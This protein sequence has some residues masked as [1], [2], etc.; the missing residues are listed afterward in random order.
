MTKE[1]KFELT[2]EEVEVKCAKGMKITEEEYTRFAALCST[3]NLNPYTDAYI[4]K[5]D[6][7]TAIMIGKDGYFKMAD[8]N[9]AYDGMEDG[10][11]VMNKDGSYEEVPGCFIKEGQTLVGGWARAYRKDRKVP[12]FAA[13]MLKDYIGS[14]KSLWGRMPA[15]MINKVAKCTALRD[16]FPQA[17]AGTYA[18]GEIDESEFRSSAKDSHPEAEPAKLA[19]EP[20][21]VNTYEKELNCIIL[22]P[23]GDQMTVRDSI[24]SVKTLANAKAV[25]AYLNKYAETNEE[26]RESI[27]TVLDAIQKG[28][29]KFPNLN[30]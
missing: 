3:N 22:S 7:K 2:K 20:V 28:E 26:A 8:S 13:V 5:T 25:M 10:I 29:I 15:I 24:A 16:L 21:P 4:I 27:A 19:E 12:K 30:K 18:E 6:F 17:F 11:I 23:K 14:A 1:N 9:P